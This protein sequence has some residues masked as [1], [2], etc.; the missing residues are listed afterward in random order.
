M[1]GSPLWVRNRQGESP[2]CQC[3][4]YQL[5][6]HKPPHTQK[7]GQGQHAHL[8]PSVY[9]SIP[10]L[11]QVCKTRPRLP[12]IPTPARC[13]MHTAANT[14]STFTPWHRSRQLEKNA[15]APTLLPSKHSPLPPCF[16][17]RTLTLP[18]CFSW[19]HLPLFGPQID[20]LP[21][22]A[23]WDLLSTQKAIFLCKKMSKRGPCT[24]EKGL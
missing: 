12:P 20:S 22:R 10:R 15:P 14:P 21:P 16:S 24:L 11:V 3:A 4:W 23:H 9:C 6:E 8:C 17:L 19:S 13:A 7:E 1:W 18:R 2:L 5:S